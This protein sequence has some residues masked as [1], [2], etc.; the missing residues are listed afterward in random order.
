MTTATQT[1]AVKISWTAKNNSSYLRGSRYARTLR[2][3]VRDAKRYANDELYG[4]G[5]ITIM[6][7]GY[8]VR[9]YCAGLLANTARFNWKRTDS[10]S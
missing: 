8:P 6:E 3:A 1:A 10:R 9:E 7:D 2:G 4:E 5:T